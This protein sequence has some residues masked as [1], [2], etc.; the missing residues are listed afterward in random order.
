MEL[1]EEQIRKGI[2]H[3]CTGELV[4]MV[5]QFEKEKSDA[6]KAGFLKAWGFCEP[7]VRP[8]NDKILEYY[9]EWLGEVR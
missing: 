3:L 8:T 9:E 7:L 1:T 2:T 4:D 6:F 5:I